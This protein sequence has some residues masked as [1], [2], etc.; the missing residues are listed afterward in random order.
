MIRTFLKPLSFLPALCLMYMIFSFSAQDGATSSQLSYKVSYKVVEVGGKVLGADFQPWEIDTLANRFHGV[1]R[2]LA[3][4]TEYFALAIAVSFPLYV[5]GLHGI[6]LML[7][8][9]FICVAFACGDEYHQSFVAGRS[10]GVRDVL[11]DSFGVFWGIILVRIIG[12]TGRKTIFRP[13]RK[14]KRGE[15]AY[16]EDYQRSGMGDPYPPEA[17]RQ[18]GRFTQARGYQGGGYPQGN[19]TAYQ[20]GGYQQGNGPAYQGGGYQQGPG[21]AYQAGGYRQGSGTAYQNEAYQQGPGPAHQSGAYQQGNGT[22]Y[23]TGGYQQGSGPAHQSGVYQQSGGPTYQNGAY[24]QAYGGNPPAGQRPSGAAAGYAGPGG[25]YRQP[26]PGGAFRQPYQGAPG[27]QYGQPAYYP[28]RQEE[29]EDSHV[30]DK[31]SEDMS[32]KK[33]MHDLKDQKKDPPKDS[34]KMPSLRPKA[35]K[36]EEEVELDEIDLDDLDDLDD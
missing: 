2:K 18:Q 12:W 24:Q 19:G 22:A 4:M 14:K 29:A 26:Y 8:A 15:P 27:G 20:S 33:L 36:A 25:G 31:L 32:L 16:A 5:Y 9:G 21:P 23:Q 3:H 30:S 17:Y 6:L 34:I 1:I 13:A 35:E 7:A 10:P 28:P 11:I